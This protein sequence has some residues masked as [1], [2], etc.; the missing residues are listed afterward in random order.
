MAGGI[1]YLCL[2][3]LFEALEYEITGDVYQLC[4]LGLV[5]EEVVLLSSSEF[6]ARVDK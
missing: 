2:C 3:G 1:G 6:R 4:R 5:E